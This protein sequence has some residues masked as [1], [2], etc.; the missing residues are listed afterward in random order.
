MP[1][2]LLKR[3]NNCQLFGLTPPMMAFESSAVLNFFIE[4]DV[5]ARSGAESHAAAVGTLCLLHCPFSGVGFHFFFLKRGFGL[6]R[7][8][9]SSAVALASGAKLGLL[10]ARQFN[11]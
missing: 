5:N 4:R 1:R 2:T 10:S 11:G 6:F 3:G 8:A 9:S 7:V